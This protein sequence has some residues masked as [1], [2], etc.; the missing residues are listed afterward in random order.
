MEPTTLRLPE[1]LARAADR[2]AE[3]RGVTRSEVI[4][5]ALEEY[6]RER[7]EHAKRGRAARVEELVRYAG[8]G[9]GDLGSRGEAYLRKRFR[10][11]RRGAR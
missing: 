5:E 11:R 7:E 4:R 8:S 2:I 6:C 1:E 9:V 3:R 10:E